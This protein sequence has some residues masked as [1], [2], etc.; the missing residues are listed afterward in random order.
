MQFFCG[1]SPPETTKT[2]HVAC[3]EKTVHLG[4][5]LLMKYTLNTDIESQHWDR[6]VKT[7][8]FNF[9]QPADLSRLTPG[10]PW[11]KFTGWLEHNFYRM[12]A[13]SVTSHVIHSEYHTRTML[14]INKAAIW[15]SELCRSY[16]SVAVS[17]WPALR[18]ET[19]TEWD[20]CG[21]AT[22]ASGRATVTGKQ[23]NTLQ[24]FKWAINIKLMYGAINIEFDI[25]SSYR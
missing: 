6:S 11:G 4:L 8:L 19:S 13:R 5:T 22:T 15:T 24:N 1:Y 3:R 20:N 2:L 23:E 7:I 10:P 18:C 25:I 9:V 14:H 16:V 21:I 12:D 17:W